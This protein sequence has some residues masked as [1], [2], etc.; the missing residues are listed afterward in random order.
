MDM[1]YGLKNLEMLSIPAPGGE[2]YSGGS[3]EWYRQF[4]RRMSGCGPTSAS[5]L[6]WYLTRSRPWAAPLWEVGD[7]GMDSFLQLMNT[8]FEYVKP[9]YKGV[10]STGIFKN[11]VLRYGQDRGVPLS[12]RI[13]D[14]PDRKELRPDFQ[15]VASFL[16]KALEEDLPAAFL[17]LSNGKMLNLDSWHWVTLVGLTPEQGTTVMLDQGKSSRIDLAL[18][19]QTTTQGGGFVVLDKA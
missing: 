12:V 14:I 17:N 10:N 7:G 4:W 1:S 19:L 3:Q 16:Q 13:L 2:M 18:W 9:G 5:N 6:V 15:Q 8:M 11:G